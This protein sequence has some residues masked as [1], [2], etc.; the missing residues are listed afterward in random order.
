MVIPKILEAQFLV[1]NYP[2]KNVMLANKHISYACKLHYFSVVPPK[3]KVPTDI[4][5]PVYL[6]DEVRHQYSEF[7]KQVEGLKMI[8]GPA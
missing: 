3:A 7:I 8:A 1:K 2:N 6:T 4:S 5:G